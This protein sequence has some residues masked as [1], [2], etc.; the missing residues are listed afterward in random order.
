MAIHSNYLNTKE[1]NFPV[2]V[3]SFNYEKRHAKPMVQEQRQ[4]RCS[5]TNYKIL[6]L[7]LI[8]REQMSSQNQ[9]SIAKILFKLYY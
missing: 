9:I 7:V 1:E 8:L 2:E 4:Q 5:D 3:S 6:F